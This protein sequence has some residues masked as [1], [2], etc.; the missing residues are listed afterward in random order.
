MGREAWKEQAVPVKNMS[1]IFAFW[2][3]PA[4][5]QRLEHLLCSTF[6]DR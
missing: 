2:S 1:R 3:W 4:C 6:K 5:K